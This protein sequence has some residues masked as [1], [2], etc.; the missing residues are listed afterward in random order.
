MEFPRQVLG[1]RTSNTTPTKHPAHAR[2]SKIRSTTPTQAYDEFM[3]VCFG[4]SPLKGDTELPENCERG[5]DMDGVRVR[6]A[7]ILGT[8]S[9][10]VKES[11]LSLAPRGPVLP[12]GSLK[13]MAAGPS[14]PATYKPAT[15]VGRQIK[16]LT[17]PSSLRSERRAPEATAGLDLLDPFQQAADDGDG[18]SGRDAYMPLRQAL[19]GFAV[20]GLATVFLWNHLS[21][22]QAQG[23]L[24]L[25]EAR[26][27]LVSPP[28][29]GKWFLTVAHSV[30][31]DPGSLAAVVE[32]ASCWFTNVLVFAA[33]EVL[34]TY[35]GLIRIANVCC[36]IARVAFPNPPVPQIIGHVQLL[37]P[38]PAV[39]PTRQSW[40]YNAILLAY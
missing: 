4:A 6:E 9:A 10:P 11:V 14:P 28:P 33:G 16:V 12:T 25:M 20:L 19:V 5:R 18:D 2:G 30:F 26:N 35:H 8:S 23:V 17:P 7:D 34:M 15:P 40:M 3:A 32:A 38:A 31:S 27:M 39:P 29:C 13:D 36:S 21:A 22:L 1:V 24:L 37:L